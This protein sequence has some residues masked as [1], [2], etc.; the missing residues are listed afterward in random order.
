MNNNFEGFTFIK[1][2]VPG[3]NKKGDYDVLL[4]TQNGRFAISIYGNLH[5][6]IV[7]DENKLIKIGLFKN[8]I[9]LIPS[10]DVA[11]AFKPYV[12][13]TKACVRCSLEGIPK[14]ARGR[15]YLNFDEKLKAYYIDINE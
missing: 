2:K 5:Q 7:D 8:R 3:A 15:R 10:K 4:S 6:L 12:E 9:Y 11:S 14:E 1:K 13:G